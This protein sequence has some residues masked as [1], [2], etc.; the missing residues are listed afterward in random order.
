MGTRSTGIASNC[1]NIRAMS[2]ADLLGGAAAIAATVSTALLLAGISRAFRARGAAYFYMRVA[3]R[4][5]AAK[6]M[7]MSLLML[8]LA[9]ALYGARVYV[10]GDAPEPIVQLLDLLQRP[11]DTPA[12]TQTPPPS[13]RT[14]PS[15]TQR[16]TQTP[17]PTATLVP[18]PDVTATPT[19]PHLTL[20]GAA[21]DVNAKGQPVTL[22]E[23][24]DARTK[25]I[26]VFFLV[27]NA[28][29]GVVVQHTWYHNAV[30]IFSQKDVLMH[31]SKTPVS[32]SWEPA[33]GFEP[34]AYEVHLAV[35]DAP[36]FVAKF[37]VR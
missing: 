15:S 10:L 17:A 18:T 9:G 16:P 21:T 25:R 1:A 24:I 32:V 5:S 8:V 3:A 36:Q 35:N 22:V 33:G 34:G 31:E 7:A 6:R 27:E 14:A 29:P 30:A 19:G 23:R 37:E 4:K 20:F 13:P 11:T 12:P 28:E 2:F 26:H